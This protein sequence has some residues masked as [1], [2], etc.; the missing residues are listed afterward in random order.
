MSTIS[1]LLIKIGAD[2]S[3]LTKALGDTKQQISQT[4]S[5]VSPLN[6]MQGALTDTT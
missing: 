5:D 1:E 2:N 6:T 4:F 3:G